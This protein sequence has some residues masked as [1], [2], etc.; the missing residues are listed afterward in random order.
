MTQKLYQEVKDELIKDKEF[1]ELVKNSIKEG[2]NEC[3]VCP[4]PKDIRESMNH[5]SESVKTIGDGNF[6]KGVERIRKNH[7]FTAMMREAQLKI[8]GWVLKILVFTLFGGLV[9]LVVYAVTGHKI[10]IK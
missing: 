2:L 10:P 9:G 8:G 7:D 5:W 6:D 4:V 1:R 3:S